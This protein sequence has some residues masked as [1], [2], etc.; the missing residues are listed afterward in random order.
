MLNDL[1]SYFSLQ[2]I[3]LPLIDDKEEI[4]EKHCAD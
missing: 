1:V 4:T 3:S 2:F